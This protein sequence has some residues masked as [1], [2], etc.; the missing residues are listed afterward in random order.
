MADFG[1][2][3]RLNTFRLCLAIKKVS[4]WLIQADLH[5]LQHM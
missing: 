1:Q 2:P 3:Y 5:L 4:V